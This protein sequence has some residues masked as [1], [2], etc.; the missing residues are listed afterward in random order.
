M[1]I[2]TIQKISISLLVG[3]ILLGYLSSLNEFFSYIQVFFILLLIL[4]C[5]PLG[6]YMY[7]TDRRKK[8]NRFTKK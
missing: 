6:L 5:I 1:N 3:I 4:Y 7:N 2:K 8:I